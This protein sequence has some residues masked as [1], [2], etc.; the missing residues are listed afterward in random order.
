MRVNLNHDLVGKKLASCY[1]DLS[2]IFNQLSLIQ[3]IAAN[4]AIGA[5]A[6]AGVQHLPG[7]IENLEQQQMR[8]DA[9]QELVYQL[10]QQQH[11][12]KQLVLL[13]VI[14]KLVNTRVIEVRFV[15]EFMLNNLFFTSQS[16]N[17]V[18]IYIHRF[19]KSLLEGTHQ[20]YVKV[21]ESLEHYRGQFF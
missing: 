19:R 13:R 3:P 15:C 14:T 20:T 18:S 12:K 11:P 5:V 1:N 4:P 10:F 16:G 21:K 2:N 17:F 7:E 8:K 6:V 9:I